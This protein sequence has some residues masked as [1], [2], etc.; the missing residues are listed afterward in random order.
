M[1]CDETAVVN[2]RHSSRRT[3]APQS[4][5]QCRSR[6]SSSEDSQELVR[7]EGA[8][9]PL[10][11]GGDGLAAPS[12]DEFALAYCYS[13]HVVLPD[14]AANTS[15]Y[16]RDEG[17]LTCM[18]ALGISSYSNIAGSAALAARA[19]LYYVDAIVSLNTALSSSATAR[20]DSTL[21]T[22]IA[23]AYFESIAGGG[24]QSIKAWAKHVQGMAALLALRGPAQMQ[25]LTGRYLFIQA[26][27]S[28]VSSCLTSGIRLPSQMHYLMDEAMRHIDDPTDPGV[29]VLML[30]MDLA[31]FYSDVLHGAVVDSE[32]ILAKAMALDHGY[33]TVFAN[34]SSVWG[35]RVQPF[36]LMGDDAIDSAFPGYVHIFGNSQ[37]AQVW[38]AVRNGRI[39]CHL[40]IRSASLQQ[41]HFAAA[42]G[43]SATA[44]MKA[45][46][47]ESDRV[48]HEMQ[49]AVLASAPQYVNMVSDVSPFVS[50]SS[51]QLRNFM[52][53]VPASV[54][55]GST[56]S[57]AIS[58]PLPALRISRGYLLLW[59]LGLAGRV[60]DIGHPIR[61][62][63]CEILRLAGRALGMSQGFALA[64]AL[65]TYK[66]E[67]AVGIFRFQ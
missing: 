40:I 64:E 56:L 50:R 4:R 58:S 6:E 25:T 7:S 65:E 48:I 28:L 42:T 33:A 38:N 47:E 44:A 27:S 60:A 1:F 35:Y 31:D 52:S 49:M 34:A 57:H 66:L 13:H 3:S 45:Q 46:V 30:A 59:G 21:L 51:E 43:T 61:R 20:H 53:A 18:K 16:V 67:K 8:T 19:R 36:G 32:F 37:A 14:H 12:I 10:I 26:L 2:E 15:L 55:H 11:V 63:V 22:V 5:K 39:L 9:P 23:L 24:I 62:A 41:L 29:R 54:A 17:L